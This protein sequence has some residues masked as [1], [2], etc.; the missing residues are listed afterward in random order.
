[1]PVGERVHAP[2]RALTGLPVGLGALGALASVLMVLGAIQPGSPFVLKRA[3]AW[4]FGVGGP[5]T[6]AAVAFHWSALP[7]MVV[8]IAGAVLLVGVWIRL[9]RYLRA[10]PGVKVRVV[11]AVLVAWALPLVIGPP[12]FSHD[13]YSYAAL[14]DM[15]G[16]GVNPYH[17]DIAAFGASGAHASYVSLVLR[18][19]RTSPTSYGPGFLGLCALA[20]R[21]TRYQ[22]TATVVVLRVFELAAVAGLA[23]CVVGL[24]RANDGD[25]AEALGLAICNPVVV[26]GLIAAGHNDS[27][28]LVGLVGGI[29]AAKRGHPVL[30]IVACALAC[31]V[32]FPA[33]LGVAFIGW[34]WLGPSV[35]WRRRVPGLVAAA[36]IAA[37]VLEALALATGLG[38]GW[39]GTSGTSGLVFNPIDPLNA[40]GLAVWSI[41]HALGSGLSRHVALAGAHYAG[42]VIGAG[43]CA[44][45]GWWS[46][47]LGWVKALGLALLAVAVLGPTIQPWYLSWALVVLLPLASGRLRSGLLGLSVFGGGYCVLP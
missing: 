16:H 41:P 28:M 11:A 44:V 13:I 43:V 26:L 31:A 39:M 15:V 7:A 4:L 9:V 33:G 25:P 2:V 19:W 29:L 40:V 24:A 10:T 47:R 21:L 23:A 18:L 6:G 35:G 42:D 3:G 36:V 34:N 22:V 38:W 30:G 17:V 32:K 20:A 45:L 12:L 5:R 37:A 1:M 27:I 46:P 8:V 14:G